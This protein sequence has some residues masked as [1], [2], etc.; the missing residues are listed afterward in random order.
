MGAGARFGPA[1]PRAGS[2]AVGRGGVQICDGTE[3]L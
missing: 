1:E 2:S 3:E